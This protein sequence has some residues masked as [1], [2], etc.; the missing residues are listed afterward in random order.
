MWQCVVPSALVAESLGCVSEQLES[1]DVAAADGLEA[2]RAVAGECNPHLF[3]GGHTC[4]E[5]PGRALDSL[6]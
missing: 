6:A 4:F 3:G 1:G 2:H 5:D